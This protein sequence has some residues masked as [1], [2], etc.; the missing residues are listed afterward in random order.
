MLTSFYQFVICV[1]LILLQRP[2][3]CCSLLR[4]SQL[5]FRTRWFLF[6]FV[7]SDVWWWNEM[8]NRGKV[9]PP[10]AFHFGGIWKANINSVKT[11]LNHIVGEQLLTYEEFRT[12][13]SQVESVP[14]CRKLNTYEFRPQTY[15]NPRSFPY[16]RTSDHFFATWFNVLDVQLVQPSIVLLVALE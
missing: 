6:S 10:R 16:D 14:N 1:L 7:I 8:V 3:H 12:R 15:P 9:N 13:I 11:H 2:H 5:D 4:I